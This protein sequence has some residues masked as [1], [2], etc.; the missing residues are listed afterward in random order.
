MVRSLK[1]RSSRANALHLDGWASTIDKGLIQKDWKKFYAVLG[2]V[3]SMA[4]VTFLGLTGVLIC[5]R[6]WSRLSAF[7]R[8]VVTRLIL[9]S[10]K[11]SASSKNWGEG[12]VGSYAKNEEKRSL[13]S[14]T[15]VVWMF[16]STAALIVKRD[17]YDFLIYLLN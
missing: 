10:F 1:G 6:N 3:T 12:I 13:K 16:S 5:S 11:A 8:A 17:L 14:S 4:I 7:W 15:V 9:S 2:S